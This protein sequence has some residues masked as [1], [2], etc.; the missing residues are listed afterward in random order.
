MIEQLTYRKVPDRI[1]NGDV[2]REMERV[3]VLGSEAVGG[4]EKGDSFVLPAGTRGLLRVEAAIPGGG[5]FFSLG[6]VVLKEGLDVSLASKSSAPA[7]SDLPQDTGTM[8]FFP[9][10]NERR[11]TMDALNL[12]GMHFYLDVLAGCEAGLRKIDSHLAKEFIK[13]EGLSTN[14]KIDSTQV[15][16]ITITTGVRM[17]VGR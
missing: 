6:V 3:S 8:S 14:G 15:R 7:Q 11:S 9:D 13:K 16:K 12:A 1:V 10:S 5:E 2:P 4:L 17:P